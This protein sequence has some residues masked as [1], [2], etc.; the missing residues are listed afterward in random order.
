MPP[1]T[2]TS[3]PPMTRFEPGSP[4]DP[5]LEFLD[6]SIRRE[7]RLEAL[8]RR[9]SR[10][11]FEDEARERLRFEAYEN[12]EH[13]RILRRHRLDV[14]RGLRIVAPAPGARVARVGAT[15]TPEA[16]IGE[17]LR[18]R[19]AARDEY[20]AVFDA[21]GERHLRKFVEV[22]ARAQADGFR[23]LRETAEALGYSMTRRPA[24]DRPQGPVGSRLS[25]VAAGAA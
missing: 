19:A 13:A 24:P 9:A 12:R 17:S 5:L 2:E 25:A 23:R 20:R 10:G 1:M 21:I 22:L 8:L 7:R 3:P 18:L 11:P 14:V 16:A 6:R 4:G 15:V